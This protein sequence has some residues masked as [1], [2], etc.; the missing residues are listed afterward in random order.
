MGKIQ[1]NQGGKHKM[2]L[3][4]QEG[5]TLTVLVITI[6]IILLIVGASVGTVL[7]RQ[8]LLKSAQQAQQVQQ[9]QAQKEEQKTN[10][11]IDS[12][13][14]SGTGI[15][16]INLDESANSPKLKEG[17]I[18]VKW[19]NGSWVVTDSGDENWY[20]YRGKQWANVMLTDEMTVE[21]IVDVTTATMQE[22]KGKRVTNVGSMF[23]WIPRYAYKITQNYHKGGDS[24]T[25][26][27]EVCFLEDA[28]NN[29]IKEGPI[30]VEYNAGTT[31]NYTSFPEG[32]V[33]HPAF[34]YEQNITGL[35]VAKFEASHTGCTTSEN[36]GSENTNVTT[37][38]LQVKPGV[39]SWRNI[40]IGTSYSVCLNYRPTLNS[41]L[42]KNTEW[43]AVAYLSQSTCGK[44]SKIYINNSGS[45][46]TGAAGDTAVASQNT[47][48]N[49]NY[50][51][52]QGM[53][54]S[55]TGNVT[56]I[57]DMAGGAWEYTASYLENGY[58][59]E[60]DTDGAVNTNN[61]YAVGDV[62]IKGANKTKFIY[63][64]A[65]TDDATSNYGANKE[66]YGDAIYEVSSNSISNW[67]DS[68]NAEFSQFPSTETPFMVRGGDYGSSS[69]AGF[70]AFKGMS[71]EP[72]T[73][74]SFRPVLVVL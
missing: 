13:G 44:G 10:D 26:T 8:G 29:P 30:V 42:M 9:N 6:L 11:L 19:E 56:G 12:V 25:G 51:S 45:Y 70:Y 52:Q 1:A 21:G 72:A 64:V 38:T 61:R 14:S 28:T 50:T 53:Q 16:A 43:G 57:Y 54:A 66:K 32:Y 3:K 48:V 15:N 69:L 46:I 41:H 39:T 47:N 34:Q 65:S 27:V 62:L 22:M 55:S 24:I 37:K 17:M 71:G 58:V 35:W 74:C 73:N 68:W 67:D 4:K 60:K 40:Q 49:T 31:K 2:N 7:S 5:I 18:P 63:A 36:T 59:K 33:V 20:N 23:V